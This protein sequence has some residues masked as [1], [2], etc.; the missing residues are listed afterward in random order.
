MTMGRPK[1]ELMLTV[2]EQEQLRSMARSRSLPAALSLRAKFVL[3]CASGEPNSGVALRFGTTNATVGKWRRRFLDRRI[4]GLYDELRPGK[5]RSISDERVAELINKTLH[6]KPADG[7][8]HWS[9]RSMGAQTGISP[10][11]VHRYFKLFDLQPHRT[12]SFKLSEVP[13]VFRLPRSVL[14]AAVFRFC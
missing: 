12:K 3:A 11:S 14:H 10:T 5:P 6:T 9:V 4:N 1:A 8:T 13:S 7:A 2:E